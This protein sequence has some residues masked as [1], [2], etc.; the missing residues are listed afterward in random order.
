MFAK[1]GQSGSPRDSK[2]ISCQS[3]IHGL[4]LYNIMYDNVK[5]IIHHLVFKKKKKKEQTGLVMHF[6]WAELIAVPGA[7]VG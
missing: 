2:T 7:C 5:C 3:H 6:L 1:E 4:H